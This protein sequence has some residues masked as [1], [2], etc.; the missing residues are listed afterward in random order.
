MATHRRS[1]LLVLAFLV[2]SIVADEE[3]A[4]SAMKTKELKRFL[5]RKGKK[6]EGCAEKSDFVSLCEASIG[7]PDV[8]PPQK[9]ADEAKVDKERSIEDILASLKG[10]PGMG[11]VK[12]RCP[13]HHAALVQRARTRPPFA[14]LTGAPQTPLASGLPPG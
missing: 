3:V 12:V 2:A 5:A 14:R 11:D 9:T 1:L 6:C 10:M 7:L 8:P 4:C 13:I